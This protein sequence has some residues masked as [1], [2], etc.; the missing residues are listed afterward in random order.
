LALIEKRSNTQIVHVSCACLANTLSLPDLGPETSNQPDKFENGVF[1]L[2]MQ[3]MFNIKT[4][5]SLAILNLCLS[6]TLTKKS[7]IIVTSSFLKS[8]VFKMFSVHTK[9]QSRRFQIPTVL[10]SA[11]RKPRFIS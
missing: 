10:K 8:S 6:E 4:Q 11:S 9:T 3:Q 1:I 5:Q 7:L 2:E